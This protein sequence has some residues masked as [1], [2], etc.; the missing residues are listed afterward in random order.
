MNYANWG[1]RVGAYIVDIIPA[2]ILS[3]IGY[4]IDGP[5]VNAD[6]T[7]EGMGAIYW[8][9]VL[10]AFAWTVYNR[11]ILGGQGASIGKKA[12][13]LR[14]SKEQTGQPLGAGGAFVRDLAHIVD[15]IICLIGY[16]F[17]LWD[18]KRQT[19]ADKIVGSLVV[20]A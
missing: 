3:G 19:I 15:S 8:I 14:L 2:A 6:A 18:Q 20:K 17:P 13:G 5:K 1:Q 12:L 11:W 10:L 16:L 9:C 7:M 4:A